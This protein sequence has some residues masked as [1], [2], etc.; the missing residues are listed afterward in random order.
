LIV[1]VAAIRESL[2][3]QF[4]GRDK[5]YFCSMKTKDSLGRHRA[6]AEKI[7]IWQIRFVNAVADWIP[8]SNSGKILHEICMKYVL[9]CVDS[10]HF[11]ATIDAL[12]VTANSADFGRQ[13]S[14]MTLNVGEAFLHNPENGDFQP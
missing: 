9:P 14:G 12:V 6:P 8:P 5:K 13:T 10:A 1:F 2:K 3:K 11:P 7:R 4:Y